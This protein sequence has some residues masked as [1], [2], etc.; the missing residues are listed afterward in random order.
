MFAVFDI[1]NYL[2]CDYCQGLI[3]RQEAIWYGGH[4]FHSQCLGTRNSVG[5]DNEDTEVNEG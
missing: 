1:N 4:P 2:E 3:E 5:A